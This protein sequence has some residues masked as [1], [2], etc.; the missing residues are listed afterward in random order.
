L[1]LTQL[2]KVLQEIPTCFIQQQTGV[3][4]WGFYKREAF[5]DGV[6]LESN[7]NWEGGKVGICLWLK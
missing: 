4:Y 5:W 2:G 3:A 6:W 7:P 1:H